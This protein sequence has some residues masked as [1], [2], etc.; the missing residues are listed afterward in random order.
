MVPRP[1]FDWSN[2]RFILFVAGLAVAAIGGLVSSYWNLSASVA[3]LKLQCENHTKSLSTSAN[4]LILLRAELSSA[5]SDILRQQDKIAQLDELKS[6]LDKVES[7]SNV[8]C[9]KAQDHITEISILR[10]NVL[11]D[12]QNIAR[13]DPLI[14]E[15]SSR[16]TALE[17]IRENLS[18]DIAKLREQVGKLEGFND[19]IKA[20]RAK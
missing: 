12:G 3:S 16:V 2:N 6:K 20:E 19:A 7:A 13:L 15:V 8:F 1:V 10:G 17:S 5:K 18:D 9:Q 14:Q 11:T 4:E